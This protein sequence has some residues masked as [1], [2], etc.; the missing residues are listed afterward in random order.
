[1]YKRLDKNTSQLPE[2]K[3]DHLFPMTDT[4]GIFQHAS[5]IVP[6]FSEGYCT[7]D[8][9]RALVLALMLQRL[10]KSS[11]VLQARATTYVAFLNHAFDRESRRFRNFMSFD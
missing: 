3:L 4:T 8:N 5:F 6:N 1:T 11:P 2:L 7:D 10:G 9:A